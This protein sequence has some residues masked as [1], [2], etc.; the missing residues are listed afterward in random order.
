MRLRNRH[1]RTTL[2]GYLFAAPAIL[3]LVLWVIGPMIASLVLSFTDWNVLTTPRWIGLTN[4]VRLFTTDPFFRKSLLVTGY[5][6]VANI[7]MT[8]LYAF[9]LALLLNQDIKGKAAFR[10]IYYL[11]TIVPVVASS[12]LWLWLYNPDFGLFNVILRELHLRRSL[13]LVD[14]KLVIPSLVLMSVWGT[15][16]N[17]I[18]IFLAGLQGVPRQLLEAVEIDGG[19][20]WHKLRSVTL[21]MISPVIFFN[22]VIGLIFSFQIFTQAY[23]MTNGGP[24]NAS[25]FYVFLLY[26][27]GFLRN[28]L[29]GAAALAWILFLIVSALTVLIF[30]SA[31]QWVYYEAEV[32]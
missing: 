8:I 25:L 17:T 5:F 20:W 30:R 3:G 11:P 10:S 2:V 15:S 29:G 12:L 14:E 31:R 28:N 32:K 23:I 22:L 13:W 18:V 9:L 24:N 27:E 6:A 1:L 19:N 16:G 21:P 26:R 7:A 4:Y